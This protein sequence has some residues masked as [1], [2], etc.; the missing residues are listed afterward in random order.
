MTSRSQSP[1]KPRLLYYND[2]RHYYL[3]CFEPPLSMEDAWIPVDE[4]ADT[5]VDVLVYGYGA[6]AC[7]PF[8]TKVGEV[9]FEALDE[10][11]VYGFRAGK[12]V[13][14][15]IERGLDPLNVLI[16]RAHARN[17][18]FYS[19][20]RLSMGA[21]QTLGWNV[22]NFAL[23][24][25]EYWIESVVPQGNC[26]HLD[27]EHTA[28]RQERFALIE[29]SMTQYDIDGFELDFTFDPAYF[30]PDAIQSNLPVMTDYVRQIRQ[31]AQEAGQQRGR[32]VPLGARVHPT[33]AGNLVVGLDVATW[34]QEKLLD[35]IVPI[36]YWPWLMD[37]GFPFEGLVQLAHDHGCAVY[38]AIRPFFL[39]DQQPSTPAM[40]RAAASNFWHKGADALYLLEMKWP[41]GEEQ[42]GTLREIGD[43]DQLRG[44]NRHYFVVPRSEEA[45][46]YEYTSP[47]PFDLD[48]VGDGSAQEAEIYIGDDLASDARA[49]LL[50][51]LRLRLR[52]NGLSAHDQLEVSLNGE[53]LPPESRVYQPV[54]YVYAWIEYPLTDLLPQA[55]ANTIGIALRSRPPGLDEPTSLQEAEVLVEYRSSQ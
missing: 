14:S 50:R 43:P 53:F 15:L 33:L 21:G 9:W 10:Y 24:H 37:P 5:Q 26:G 3:Y 23:S 44:K 27:F 36:C 45:T 38:P 19:S 7:M 48:V 49:G 30:K 52:V 22:N 47:I 18:Q 40:Y 51:D 6:G 8:D 29:E 39:N 35:F 12:N 13:R 46:K 11:P 1:T 55:G 54:S 31:L 34:L 17:M 25:P 4:V 28:V 20:L 41:L 32:P 2:S 16:E 42:R